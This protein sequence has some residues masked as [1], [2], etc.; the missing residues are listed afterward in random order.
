MW[1]IVNP[2]HWLMFFCNC[3]AFSI[4]FKSCSIRVKSSANIL[5]LNILLSIFIL[6]CF[7]HILFLLAEISI[8]KTNKYA[9]RGLPCLTPPF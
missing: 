5:N 8:A 1:I 7:S 4:D 9:D 2:E 3:S 6:L